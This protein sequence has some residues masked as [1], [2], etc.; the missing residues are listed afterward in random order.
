MKLSLIV[1]MASN[2]TIGID[3]KMPWHLSADLQH[4]K[5]VTMGCPIIMGRKTFEAIGRPLPGRDNI[6]I[7]RNT[8]YQQTGCLIFN[9]L[10]KALEHCKAEDQVFV[11]GGATLYN[12]TL[13]H[14]DSLYITQIHQDFSGD[15][16]FPEINTTEWQECEREDIT[17]D[18]RVNFNYSF[19]CYNRAA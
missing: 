13:A 3:K 18:S 16:W 4:F 5:K 11:I 10:E 6:I 14:A 12:A 8:D 19:I 9:D 17:D 1:A 15:T 2:R 7:S